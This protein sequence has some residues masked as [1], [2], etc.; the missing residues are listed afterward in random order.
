MLDQQRRKRKVRVQREGDLGVSGLDEIPENAEF[1]TANLSERKRD[2]YLNIN[3][4]SPRRANS[5]TGAL[6]A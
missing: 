4:F 1:T 3:R 6:W 5:I 2:Y